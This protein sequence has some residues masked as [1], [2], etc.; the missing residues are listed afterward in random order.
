[1]RM[2]NLP[3]WPFNWNDNKPQCPIDSLTISDFLPSE[4]DATNLKSRA[5][6]YMKGFLVSEFSSLADLKVFV[7]SSA[8]S[9]QSDP[10]DVVPMKVLFKD[11]KFTNETIDILSQLVR[12]D[13]PK[14]S[15]GQ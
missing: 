15:T 4:E 8:Q 14:R 1:M 11:E 13:R 7:A 10:S 5:I 9:Q 2:G 12:F 6:S 3:D